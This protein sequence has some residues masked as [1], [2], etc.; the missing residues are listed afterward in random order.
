MNVVVPEEAEEWPFEAKVAAISENNTIRDIREEIDGIVGF[1]DPA[2]R[3]YGG[4]E[5]SN[6]SDFTKKELV[7]LLLALGGPQ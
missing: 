2:W 3:D 1:S 4:N 5:L 7:E 6:G